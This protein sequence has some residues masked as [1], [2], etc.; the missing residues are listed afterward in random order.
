[1]K[2][3]WSLFLCLLSSSIF[4]Q[5]P[6]QNQQPPA[7]AKSVIW[8]ELFVERFCNGDSTNDPT[9][10]DINVPGQAEAPL[11]WSV[12][13]WT[14][15]WYQQE[16]WEKNTGRPLSETI[17]FRRYGGDLQGVLQKLDYLKDLGVTALYFRP[18]NDAPSLHKYDARSYH[19]IDVNFGPDPVGDKKIIAAENPAD[20]STWKWTAADKLFLQVIKEAHQR[21]MKVVLD[22][23][24]NHTGIMFWAFQDILK[25]Q[26]QAKT[27]DWYAI[28]SFDDPA[29]PQNEF[30]YDGWVGIQS[31]PEIKKVDITTPRIIGR[32]YEG[33][34]HPDVKKH[35]YDV[36]RR[37]LAPEGNVSNG[38][39]G[40]RLDV[41]D[42]IGLKF[43]REFRTVV[44]SIN[45]DAYLVGEIWWEKWPEQ[46]MNPQPYTSGDVFDA[47]MFYQIY[48]PARYFFAKTT[49]EIDARQFRDS[50]M[51]QWNRLSEPTRYAMMNV[52]SSADA[53]RLLSDFYNPGKYKVSAKPAD[54]PQY[55]T[56]KPDAESYQR[57][58]LYL[59]HA[60]TNIGAPS[61]YNGEE[62]GMWGGDDPEDR[63]PL[64]WKEL[65]F[66]L[67][68][69]TNFQ[70]GA[71]TFDKVGFN[72]DQF[73]FF[74]KLAAIRNNHPVLSTG[75]IEFIKAEG[76]MLA[77][78]RYDDKQE[79]VVLFNLEKDERKFDLP[80]AGKYID[81][82]KGESVLGGSI[83]LEPLTG[84]ILKK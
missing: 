35:I 10:Q 17:F 48:R 38:V 34:I 23:S 32:P 54:D 36:T 26:Q 11:H 45:P 67:E 83:V 55:K 81:L 60:F 1:M 70:P 41:A 53:P 29:T 8:Y 74:K 37:W 68:T 76:K 77:Y 56:G 33:D 43:W 19:H 5:Q 46:L 31:L 63:K 16:T 49:L 20:P 78:R 69:G 79:I 82:M 59:M 27:K 47:V 40:Y 13:P 50:L 66:A 71:K 39:D 72:Q 4:S 52:S 64:W 28:K 51:F 42:H 9:A 12:T 57:L 15:D 3:I 61:I 22:Y 2:F 21:K 30:A 44:K 7:W 18:L 84:M 75:K 14:A 24:W 62:L 6:V 73:K 25:N 58:R 80:S 65:K